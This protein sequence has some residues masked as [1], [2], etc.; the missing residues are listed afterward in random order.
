VGNREFDQRRKLCD[1]WRKPEQSLQIDE[2]P[3]LSQGDEDRLI[4]DEDTGEE[5][6]QDN[7]L[8]APVE[9]G[10]AVGGDTPQN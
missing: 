2:R 7:D 9:F 8:P 4:G 10:Q 1:L 6:N 5:A 3:E